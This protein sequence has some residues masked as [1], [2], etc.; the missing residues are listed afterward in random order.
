MKKEKELKKI[1]VLTSGGDAP[2]MNA[3]IRAVVL[4]GNKQGFEVYGVKDGYLGLYNNEIS[5][6]DSNYFPRVINVSGTFLGT[7][8]FLPFQNDLAVRQTCANNLKKLGVEKL[9]VIGGDGSYKGAMKL[10]ELGIKCVGL[11]A[12]IDN[13]INNTDFT[14]GFSTALNNIVDAIEK[15][16]DTSISH[17]RCS[18]IEVMGRYKGD[19]ALYGGLAAA[20]DVIVTRENLLSKQEI[21]DKVKVLYQAKKRHAIVVVTEHIFDVATLAKE[22]EKYSGFETRAQVLGHIQRGGRPT[23][24]DLVLAFRMGSYAVSLLQQ[25]I[26]DCAVGTCGLNL[27]YTHFFDVFNNHNQ[28]ND[29]FHAI[30]KL[31]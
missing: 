31:L 12:T 19:L 10:K 3:A 15:L 4:E 9:V 22:V 13:D 27:N 20:S 26:F 5:L 28:Q 23:A 1:A 18:I 11:P 2:G 16:R 7:S 30:A 8:R 14:I 25:N 29:L 6:L 24:E 17:H 21:L